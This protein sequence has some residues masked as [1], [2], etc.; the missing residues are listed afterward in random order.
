MAK[1]V[2][3]DPTVVEQ[4][5]QF[6][7]HYNLAY[8]VMGFLGFFAVLFFAFLVFWIR[9]WRKIS[10]HGDEIRAEVDR[11]FGGWGRR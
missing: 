8:W 9:Q 3:N 2:T 1:Q 7:E 11:H 5:I 10:K 6:I 4:I